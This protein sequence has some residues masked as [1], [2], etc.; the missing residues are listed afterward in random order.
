MA[1]SHNVLLSFTKQ[2]FAIWQPKGRQTV[3]EDSLMAGAHSH[4]VLHSFKFCHLTT[5][6]KVDRQLKLRPHNVL[7]SFSKQNFA[8]CQPDKQSVKTAWCPG[9]TPTSYIPLDFVIW[10]PDE[11]QTDSQEGDFKLAPTMSCI[12][13][14]NRILL[15]VNQTKARQ[16][17]REDTL[18]A[19]AHSHNVLVNRSSSSDNQT[20]GRQTVGE[21]PSMAQACPHNVL[22]SSSSKQDCVFWQQLTRQNKDRQTACSGNMDP[23]TPA[24]PRIPS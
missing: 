18:M 17:V 13:L 16:T 3:G 1:H 14:V 6:Q 19:G 12:L 9:L 22:W 4:N 10:Q 8:V 7:H 15:F 23:R 2:T 24:H 5:R 21:E 20:K 11:R